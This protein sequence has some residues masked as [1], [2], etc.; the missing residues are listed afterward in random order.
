VDI[1]NWSEEVLALQEIPDESH[2]LLIEMACPR[3]GAKVLGAEPRSRGVGLFLEPPPKWVEVETRYGEM[4]A[5]E[6]YRVH[7]HSRSES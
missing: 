6:G 3:C 1:K 4:M 5:V 7:G 2:A